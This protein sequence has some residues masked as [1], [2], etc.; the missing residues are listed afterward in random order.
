MQA[1]TDIAAGHIG[2]DTATL[3]LPGVGMVLCAARGRGEVLFIQGEIVAQRSYLAPGGLRL[4]DG[5]VVID[6]GANIGVS[7]PGALVG[8]GSS[9]SLSLAVNGND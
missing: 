3:E 4:R 8:T 9:L 5:G 7:A 2:D 6:A 1:G